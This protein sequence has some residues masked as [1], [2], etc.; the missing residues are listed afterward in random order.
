[1][2]NA[3]DTYYGTLFS[4][5]SYGMG[6]NG[7]GTNPTT[8]NPTYPDAATA[9]AAAAAAAAAAAMA[10]AATGTGDWTNM[11]SYQQGASMLSSLNQAPTM[12]VGA[13]VTNT[14]ELSMPSGPV[15]ASTP[16][17]NMTSP[18]CATLLAAVAAAA[19]A[20]AYPV[21]PNQ[22]TNVSAGSNA[23][24]ADYTA[25]YYRSSGPRPPPVVSSAANPYTGAVYPAAAGSWPYSVSPS[26]Y[27]NS[28]QLIDRMNPNLVSVDGWT[29]P[30][31]QSA[32]IPPI[33]SELDSSCSSHAQHIPSTVF[34][35][36][37][38]CDRANFVQKDVGQSYYTS[39]ARKMTTSNIPASQILPSTGDDGSGLYSVPPTE[40]HDNAY[41]S[42]N[43]Y[44]LINGNTGGNSS[45]AA[46]AY[47]HL[48]SFTQ[49]MCQ[50]T[51]EQQR[52]RQAR[53]QQRILD[54]FS[55]LSIENNRDFPAASQSGPAQSTDSNVN[56]PP[57]TTS[58]AQWQYNEAP[59]NASHRDHGSRSVGGILR[60]HIPASQQQLSGGISLSGHT[61]QSAAGTPQA[62]TWANIAGQPPKGSAA[63][64]MNS[65][66]WSVKRTPAHVLTQGS[67]GSLPI[68]STSAIV[69]K[70]Q[71]PHT[72]SVDEHSSTT[73]SFRSG[74]SERAGASENGHNS[75]VPNT[76]ESSYE[77]S[78]QLLQ[79]EAELLHQRLAKTI[80]PAKFDTNVEKARFFVI[81]S[82][83]EDDIHRSIK[84]SV[85]CSTELGNKKLD[86]AFVEAKGQYPVYLFYSVNGSGHFCGMAEMTSRVDYDARM[87]VWAQDKWQGAFSVRWIFVKDVP[88]TALRHIRVETNENK[89]VTH[90]R[91]TT[92]LPLERGRQVMEVFASYSHTLSIFDDFV[93]YEQRERQDGFRRK[94]VGS[95]RS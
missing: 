72:K 24:N 13:G 41:L 9:S 19:A 59:D 65:T 6:E 29:S 75:N 84:Y 47:N 16:S 28:S 70:P 4:H 69:T 27:P 21:H 50:H 88:N 74:Q 95:R 40:M 81:K 7:T 79:R 33:G 85:W 18:Y 26:H 49:Q 23:V 66:G 2:T 52:Q 3:A 32:M 86:A 57:Q 39:S 20:A 1:M 93:F 82:F 22:S 42:Q 91:D 5:L 46:S 34:S 45:A 61:T 17:T 8:A 25:L 54:E 31:G 11:N 15:N 92:E 78:L 38:A 37:V 94:E 36:T 71:T 73:G 51:V 89:P 62:K 35:S 30:N 68:P 76:K 48:E 10:A 87:R 60:P 64:L 44:Q 67:R 56:C 53:Q 80:N 63:V 58:S 14:T 90:S 55:R 43:S 83:S 12:P 77:E